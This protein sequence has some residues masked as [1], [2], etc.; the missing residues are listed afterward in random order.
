MT[1][2]SING[3]TPLRDC[4]KDVYCRRFF[5]MY[6]SPHS[7]TLRSAKFQRGSRVFENLVY[8]EE[9][10]GEGGLE[11]E[12]LAYVRRSAS[13][14]LYADDAGVVSNS[15]NDLANMTAIVTVSEI[16]GL[17]VSETKMETMLLR[18]LN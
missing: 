12:P 2:N 13:G 18:T 3:M 8:L 15:T 7:N 10:V 5:A 9:D 6:F 17:T 16:A 1:V 11:V 4:G 14:M